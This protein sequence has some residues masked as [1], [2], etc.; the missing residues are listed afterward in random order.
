[1][2]AIKGKLDHKKNIFFNSYII[3]YTAYK[4]HTTA[5]A[6]T[7]KNMNVT[8]INLMQKLKKKKSK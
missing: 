6:Q 7:T 3:Y 5:I 8:L 1:M 2:N 4:T